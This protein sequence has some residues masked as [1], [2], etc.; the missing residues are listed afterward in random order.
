MH[1][2]DLIDA[3]LPRPH[4]N[5]QGLSYGQLTVLWLTYIL[6]QYD[7][8]LC[9]VEVWARER[10]RT[11]EH[12]T[13]WTIGDKDL[14][15]DRLADVLSAVGGPALADANAT[16]AEAMELALGQHLIRAY[17]LPTAVARLDTTSLSVY[18]GVQARDEQPRTLLHYGHSKDGHP[19]RRQFI[20]ALGTLDPV[21]VPLVTATLPGEQADGPIYLPQWQRLVQIIGHAEF[22]LVADSKLSSRHNRA[23]LQAQGGFYLCPLAMVGHHEAWLRQWVLAPSAEM[24]PLVFDEATWGRGFELTLGQ[25]CETAVPNTE[26]TSRVCWEERQLVIQ[27]QAFAEREIA[28]LDKRLNT[29]EA[30]LTK[31]ASHPG[32]TRAKL[33]IKV[34]QLLKKYRVAEFFD[35]DLIEEVTQEFRHVGRGRPGVNRPKREVTH[36]HLRLKFDRRPEAIAR[37]KQLAGWRLYVT[38]APATRL[39]LS[40]AVSHYRG[41]WQPERGFHRFKSGIVSALPIYLDDE[42]RIRGL[43]LVLGLALRFLTLVEFVVRQSLVKEQLEVAGLYDGNPKRK[44]Q[45]PT[46]ERLLKAFANITLYCLSENKSTAYYLTPLS[47]LQKQLLNLMHVPETIYRVPTPKPSG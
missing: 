46:T 43:M 18:H 13:G 29:A 39:S 19:E 41:Q 3:A 1:V 26:T 44:T 36:T 27:S 38:N 34:Q 23:Q 30:A 10:R 12:A 21:G 33:E 15:D 24:H 17:A 31:I 4:G 5:H 35:I 45:R 11:L 32:A 22:V 14:T 9:V 20:E 8:R 25:W 2:A 37:E 42:T 47:D 40:A 7:H 6:T 28:S 16:P